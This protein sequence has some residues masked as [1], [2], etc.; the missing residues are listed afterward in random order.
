MKSLRLPSV[1]VVAS[2]IAGLLLG[3]ARAEDAPTVIKFSDPAKPGT[4]KIV[5]GHGDLQIVAAD[6]PEVSIRSSVKPATQK[7]RK[8]GLRVLTTA[9]SFALSEKDNVVTLDAA[10]DNWGKGAGDLK[11]AVPRNASIVVQ[12]TMGGGGNIT[13]TGIGGDIEINSLNGEIRLN[14]LA[15]GAIVSTLNGE[16]HAAVRELRDNKPLS[17]TS[18]NG[19]VELRVPA[20]AK[21]NL[22]FRTQ[23]GSVATDFEEPA[24][25]TK[26]ENSPRP[27]SRSSARRLTIK[28]KDVNISTAETVEAAGKAAAD[29]E[30]ARSDLARATANADRQR[31]EEQ[32]SRGTGWTPVETFTFPSVTPGVPTITGGSLVTGT[33]NG[34][35]PEISV[36]TMNSDIK[37][38]KK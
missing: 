20:T 7:P 31:V 12:S 25:A 18:M 24:L 19:E 3:T 35:G 6:A 22:R 2:A 30:R 23:N 34:G 21:A 36:S 32:R 1:F 33:L 26:I 9:S 13:C 17:F 27:V 29:V 28:G 37:L 10:S 11:I 4:V 8:D 5:F 15:G 16:I 38:V 14:D